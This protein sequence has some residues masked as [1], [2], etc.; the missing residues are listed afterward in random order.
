[1]INLTLVFIIFHTKK[2]SELIF[3]QQAKTRKRC[4]RNYPITRLPRHSTTP[5]KALSNASSIPLSSGDCRRPSAS[6]PSDS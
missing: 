2:T 6:E 1:M 3:F 5:P 4:H